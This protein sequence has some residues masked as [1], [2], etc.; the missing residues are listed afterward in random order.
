LGLEGRLVVDIARRAMGGSDGRGGGGGEE[1]V[2]FHGSD[3]R[4]L[5]FPPSPSS[6]FNVDDTACLPC[7]AP[8][9]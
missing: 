8:L 1:A 6:L 7:P 5:P 3:G 4:T 2:E 9:G